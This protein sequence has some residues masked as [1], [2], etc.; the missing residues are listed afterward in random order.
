MA[1]RHRARAPSGRLT[2]GE[3]ETL[4]VALDAGYSS[5]EAFTRA[6]RAHFDRTPSAFRAERRAVHRQRIAPMT[7]IELR[8]EERAPARIAYVRH[9]GPYDQVGE[10]WGKL[11]KW[12]W[13]KMIFGKPET[14]GLCHDDPEVTPPERV[15]YDACMVVDAKT[16]PKGAVQMTDLPGGS[17]AV[18]L[19]EGPYTGLAETYARLFARIASGPVEGRQ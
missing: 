14:F 19:H 17:Y 11:M 10:A 9:V 4:A 8:I 5:H 13:K 18:A 16:K 12:G 1:A 7:E 15:R 2:H 3:G 6:F